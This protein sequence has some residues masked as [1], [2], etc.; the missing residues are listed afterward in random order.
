LLVPASVSGP[1]GRTLQRALE[2]VG[3]RE[4]LAAALGISPADLD[5]YLA[6]DKPLPD[7]LFH[8]ALDIVASGRQRPA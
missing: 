2:I 8:A 6:E 1:R 7:P 4:R 5:A 3:T